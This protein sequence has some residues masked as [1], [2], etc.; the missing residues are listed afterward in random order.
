MNRDWY[1]IWMED[2][3]TGFPEHWLG[4]SPRFN[5]K[6]D[7]KD[8]LRSTVEEDRGRHETS[9]L[10]EEPFEASDEGE[11][12]HTYGNS[13]HTYYRIVDVPAKDT[14]DEG[15][16]LAYKE[17]EKSLKEARTAIEEIERTLYRYEGDKAVAVYA[18]K[19]AIT[20]WKTKLGMQTV[21]TYLVDVKCSPSFGVWQDAHSAEEAEDIV[22]TRLDSGMFLLNEAQKKE[23]L[24]Q[25]T[26]SVETVHA[27]KKDNE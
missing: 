6:E 24:D 18:A 8:W 10:E 14:T 4:I 13:Q 7:A 27:F 5:S 15:L 16:S 1:V 23:I 22:S 26:N 25:V 19:K 12:R 9:K 17:L 2:N 11:I 20:E 3:D 21:K